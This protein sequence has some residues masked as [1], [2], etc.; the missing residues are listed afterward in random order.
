MPDV[1]STARG[2]ELGIAAARCGNGRLQMQ[3]KKQ[4]MNPGLV[5]LA[6][7]LGAGFVVVVVSVRLRGLCGRRR[8][9]GFAALLRWH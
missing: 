3:V 9:P 7:A 6:T 5:T 4:G 2:P 1:C 8:F